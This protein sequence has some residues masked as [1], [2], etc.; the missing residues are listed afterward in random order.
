MIGAQPTAERRIAQPTVIKRLRT[1]IG[2]SLMFSIGLLFLFPAFVYWLAIDPVTMDYRSSRILQ[3]ANLYCGMIGF[4]LVTTSSVAR[5]IFPKCAPVLYL[6]FAAFASIAW[7]IAPAQSFRA[8]FVFTTTSL[9]GIAMASRMDIISAIKLLVRTM[10]FGCALSILFV[11][12]MPETAVHQATDAVQFQHAGLWRGIFS[13][14]QGLG[15]FAGMTTALLM[16]YGGAAL[17]PAKIVGLAL[18]ITCLVGS[19]SATGLLLAIV[20]TAMLYGTNLMA[21]QLR[22]V[23]KAMLMTL[24]ISTALVLFAF[25]AGLLDFI[26]E[27]L[28][29]SSDLTG[30]AESWPFVRASMADSGRSLLGGGFGSGF[31]AFVA[32]GISIDNGYLDKLVEFGYI[33]LS[34]VIFAYAKG[35]I[36]G[37]KLI[38]KTTRQDSRYLI[39]PFNMIFLM[40]FENIAES[41]FMMKN[42]TTV[43]FAMCVAYGVRY[44]RAAVAVTQAAPPVDR[45]MEFAIEPAEVRYRQLFPDGKH[46]DNEAYLF[47]THGF[48]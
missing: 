27:L 21:K 28:G 6:M 42:I 26:P 48:G 45:P 11:V 22:A 23:R 31:T 36:K 46:Q 7:S 18:S 43:M 8:C 10:T 33:G 14:K 34:F 20:G 17:G 41:T 39:F 9:L 32:P 24:V 3:L 35:L 13:H 5:S 30:R 44:S 15:V 38:L 19:G 29:K 47:K 2:T 16:F 1:G 12:V 4:I 37:A 40:M 25:Q